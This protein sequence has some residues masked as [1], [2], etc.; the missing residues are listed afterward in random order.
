MNYF[1]AI[2]YTISHIFLLLFMYLLILHRYSK[3]I[4]GLICLSVFL[5]LNILDGFKL[6]G[7]PNSGLC[8]VVVTILQILI[9]QSTAILISKRRNS[10]TMF[11]GL[12][13]SSYV[14]AGSISAAILKIY[15]GSSVLA[16]A[17]SAA[18]H[19]TILMILVVRIRTTCL[20]FQDR[21]N[22]KECWELCLIPVFFY[23]SFSFLAFFP[24]T[25]Y[26]YPDNIPG[27]LF[28]AITMFVSYLAVLHYLD[29]ETKRNAIYWEN[30]LQKSYI[31]GL[32]S[33]HYLVEQAERNLKILHHDIRHYTR[34]IDSLLEQENYEKIKEVNEHISHIADENKV[35]RYCHNLIVNTILSEM[36]DK[37]RSLAVQV[38]L[39]ARVPKE[40]P[41]NEYE[42]TLVIANLFENALQCVQE[43]DKEKRYLEMKIQC[44]EGYLFV[45]TRNPYQEELLLDPDTGLPKS[46]KS[47][48]HGMGMQSIQAFSEKIR[49]TLG[50]CIDDGIFQMMLY[51]KF[52]GF[53][54]GD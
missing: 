18:I 15:T 27:I 54:Q 40:I 16:L 14:I 2:S 17:G 45:Q 21:S 25:L 33:R 11:V 47:G 26:E 43:F 49:G 1:T 10:Q 8:Y 24:K 12:S 6:I 46:K 4:T 23:C 5:A 41:V 36:M 9:T 30:M 3:I 13:A 22:E 29:S 51:A 38:A 20:K 53:P 39:E 48:N 32:E 7:F 44:Q 34:M 31:Q 50:C 37:A 42:F 52:G 19:V 28:T 35:E